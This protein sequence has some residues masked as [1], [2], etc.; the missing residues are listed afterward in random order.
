MTDIN[1][2][3][4]GGRCRKGGLFG[5]VSWPHPHEG[6]PCTFLRSGVLEVGGLELVD[7]VQ[8]YLDERLCPLDGGFGVDP[9]QPRAPCGVG[10]RSVCRPG[11]RG[12]AEILT[13]P[14]GT[15]HYERSTLPLVCAVVLVI[16]SNFF[17]F[18][19]PSVLGRPGTN[20]GSFSWAGP[21]KSFEQVD[22]GVRH[23][24][25]QARCRTPRIQAA[26]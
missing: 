12:R 18:F 26:T 16:F 13:G 14:G 17:F 25:C 1:K 24:G 5:F 11:D 6:P 2:R 15:H 20:G 22:A 7:T 10:P 3:K 21:A 23:S 4:L 9:Y 8:W 19:L